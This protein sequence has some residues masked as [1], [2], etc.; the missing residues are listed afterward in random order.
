MTE[1]EANKL[2]NERYR[3]FVDKGNWSG[4]ELSPENMILV[5]SFSKRFAL[6]GLRL[7]FVRLP[8]KLLRAYRA[9][10]ANKCVGVS[11]VVVTMADRLLEL[12]DFNKMSEKIRS[13]IND[14]QR[15][16]D[17]VSIELER[18]GISSIKPEYGMY[19][20]FMLRGF[21]EKTGLGSDALASELDKRGVKVLT[22]SSFYPHNVNLSRVND[23]IRVSV[24]GDPRIEEAGEVMLDTVRKLW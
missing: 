15:K 2:Y 18:Y 16:L 9:C 1:K 7:G 3:S 6:P 17:N 13:E 21:K 22:E 11:N 12:F 23:F 20:I 19:R 4:A 10:V 8:Q 5:D 14:R 24:G